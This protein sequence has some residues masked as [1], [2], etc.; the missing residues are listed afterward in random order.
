MRYLI[1]VVL[2]ITF[3]S[4][5]AVNEPVTVIGAKEIATIRY[6][7]TPEYPSG[8]YEYCGKYP[9]REECGGKK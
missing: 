2:L 3:L 5:C 4:G 8:F 1:Q 6:D 9:T 7:K